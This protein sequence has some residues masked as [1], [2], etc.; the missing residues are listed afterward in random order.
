MNIYPFV[1]PLILCR[2]IANQFRVLLNSQRHW[3]QGC[4][5]R[6]CWALAQWIECSETLFS[7]LCV[8]PMS[9]FKCLCYV[10]ES[11]GGFS[12]ERLCKS[13]F[14]AGNKNNISICLLLT[15]FWKL[16][17]SYTRVKGKDSLI[18][19]NG[20]EKR[21]NTLKALKH[22]MLFFLILFHIK[23]AVL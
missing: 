3:G 19:S 16:L 11:S 14:R 20:S 8:S 17:F 23:C 7:C 15:C 4:E 6:M 21:K 18:L 1:S 2:G 13:L 9:L 10:R 5:E 22:L 12:W